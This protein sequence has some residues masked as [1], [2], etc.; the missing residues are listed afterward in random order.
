MKNCIGHVFKSDKKLEKYICVKCKK[1][2]IISNEEKTSYLEIIFNLLEKQV[3][4]SLGY[5]I[6]KT[7]H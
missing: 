7:F 4:V 3:K 6:T 5:D 2:K 1:T